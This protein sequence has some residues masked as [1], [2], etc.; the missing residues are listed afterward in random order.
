MRRSDGVLPAPVLSKI[1]LC[2]CFDCLSITPISTHA[3][4]ITAC[5]SCFF[6]QAVFAVI[7]V[8]FV[9]IKLFGGSKA[10]ETPKAKAH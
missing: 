7:A 6:M 10:E 9:A 8:G 2:M 4:F 1:S 5:L 3:H